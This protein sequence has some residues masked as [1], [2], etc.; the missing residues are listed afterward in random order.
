MSG[1]MD[2]IGL[3]G[4]EEVALI[5]QWLSAAQVARVEITGPDGARLLIVAS[6]DSEAEGEVEDRVAALLPCETPKDHAVVVSTSGFGVFMPE[7]LE[8]GAKVR[9]GGLLAML[10]IDAL[11]WPVLAPCDGVL[12]EQLV[13]A[14]SLVGY[15]E[16]VFRLMPLV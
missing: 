13:E 7:A 15:G 5:A 1:G 4:A 11:S 9:E 12:I 6:G 8:P 3:P 10:T 2:S 14:F 16:D